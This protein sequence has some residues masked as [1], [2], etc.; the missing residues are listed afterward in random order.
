[1]TKQEK[2]SAWLKSL[3]FE[4]RDPGDGDS[5]HYWFY[6]ENPNNYL[7]SEQATFFYDV[8]VEAK[9][10]AKLEVRGD[11]LFMMNTHAFGRPFS[12][13]KVLQVTKDAFSEIEQDL[14][15]L[16]QEGKTNG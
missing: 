9:L 13:E 5:S 12:Y 15:H 2:V 11:Y 3:N 1:M 4:W 6:K 14:R 8:M 10:R 16:K 7:T